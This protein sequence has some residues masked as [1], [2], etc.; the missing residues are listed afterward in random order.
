VGSRFSEE[1]VEG[2]RKL[3]NQENST[4]GLEAEKAEENAVKRD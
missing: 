1:T 4:L 3:T 2:F